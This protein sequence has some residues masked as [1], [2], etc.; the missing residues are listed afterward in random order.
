MADGNARM[1]LLVED[2]VIIAMSTKAQLEQYGYAVVI[3]TKGDQAIAA[4]ENQP[5]IQLV[6]MDINLGADEDGTEIA[7]QILKD[8]DL[9]VLFLSAHTEPE[10]VERTEKITSYGYVVK[11][12]SIAVLDASIKMA[13]KLFAAKRA[14]TASEQRRRLLHDNAGVG[15]VYY[16]PDGRVISCNRRAAERFQGDP[17][18]FT[19]RSIDEVLP[20]DHADALRRRIKTATRNDEAFV[21][22]D[23]VQSPSGVMWLLNNAVRMTDA[24]NAITGVQIVSQDITSLKN[25]EESLK[26]HQ[27][28]L[29]T[30][31]AELL[32]QKI[33]LEAMTAKYVTLYNTAPV[34]YFT[35]NESGVIVEANCMAEAQLAVDRGSLI[36]RPFSDFIQ[37]EDQDRFYLY[38]RNLF[39][40]PAE[41]ACEHLQPQMC[42]LQIRRSDGAVFPAILKAALIQDHCGESVCR[43][44][45]VELINDHGLEHKGAGGV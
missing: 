30:Q 10:V 26:T 21:F 1:I 43:V 19:G 27:L 23:Q 16:S 39:L 31:N 2:E 22:E 29:E 8:H 45:A 34:S 11:N 36:H 38:R 24:T 17:D 41:V 33:E 44:V 7:A 6:L 9:P 12:S 18:D 15:I 40:S 13:F 35:L 37:P 14:L 28:E 3:A 5:D 32:R 20:P 4:I 25:T 42:H